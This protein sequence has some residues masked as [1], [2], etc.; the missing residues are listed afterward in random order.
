ML[1]RHDVPINTTLMFGILGFWVIYINGFIFSF[2]S[3]SPTLL[4]VIAITSLQIESKEIFT[5]F[6]ILLEDLGIQFSKSSTLYLVFLT[7]NV[8]SKGSVSDGEH[9]AFLLY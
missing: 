5:L 2:A 4:D 9:C 6:S 8:K 7:V 1:Y 3:T